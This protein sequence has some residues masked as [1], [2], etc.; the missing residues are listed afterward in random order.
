[1]RFNKIIRLKYGGRIFAVKIQ[2]WNQELHTHY[3][4]TNQVP[5]TDLFIPFW[6]FKEGIS[7]EQVEDSLKA[8]Q[9]DDLLGDIYII[10]TTPKLSFRAF[11]LDEMAFQYFVSILAGTSDIDISYLKHSVMRG[12]AV[13]RISE[14]DGTKNKLV[15]R[16]SCGGEAKRSWHHEAFFNAI[17]PEV[18]LTREPP[19]PIRVRVSK[20]ESFR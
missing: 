3:G 16:M 15:E 19:N 5:D 8:V 12:R 4:I 14:K 20:Y 13:I 17:Y 7:L 2:A 6:D 18:S 9:E 11:S 1:M 10:Q